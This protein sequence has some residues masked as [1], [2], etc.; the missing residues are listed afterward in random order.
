MELI[1]AE[2][3]HLQD[4]VWRFSFTPVRHVSWI[5]GQFIKLEVP[6][7]S[8][9]VAGE[10]RWFT[11]SAAPY[12]ATLTITTRI[13]TS[14]FKLALAELKPGDFATMTAAPAGDFIWREASTKHLFVAQGIGITPFYA[15]IKDQIYQSKPVNATLI[16][17]NQPASDAIYG[18]QLEAWS[19]ADS[20]FCIKY[21]VGTLTAA[22]LIELMPDFARSYVYVS[23]PKSFVSLCI[24]PNTLPLNHLKQDNFPGYGA[25]SY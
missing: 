16:S 23:G 17:A 12:E 11:I 6:H 14:S 1:L 4:S 20:T 8:P 18:Q 19:R 15:I 25:A 24:S 22:K 13:T 3:I 21:Y 5:A 9:D 10:S 2:K 7:A